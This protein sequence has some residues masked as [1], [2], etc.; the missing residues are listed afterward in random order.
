MKVIFT[1]LNLFLL[2]GAILLL[3]FTVLTGSS[4]HFPLNRF[5]W[6]EADTS[7]ISGAYST[8]RWTFWGVCDSGNYADCLL[9]PAYPISPVDNFG[10]TSG[11]PQKFVDDRDVYYYLTRFAFAFII[12]TLCFTALAFIIDILGFCFLII[13]KV[14]I[15]LVSLALFFM[16]GGAAL[17][18]AAIV[19]ARNAFRDDGL[20]AHIGTKSMALLWASFGCLLVVWVNTFSSNIMNS[21]HKHL[22][23]VNSEKYD[24]EPRSSTTVAPG[25]AGDESSFTR[26][27]PEPKDE[28]NNGGGIRYFKI[29]RNQK[30]SDEESV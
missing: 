20:Y 27:A 7:N 25:A 3:V 8:S 21:I 5:Y 19:L 29:K 16:A 2:A 26:T 22:A 23:N 9:G 13:D 24:N 14:V 1:I 11:I 30:T 6:L 10:N 28:E 15:C 18:T 4:K 17:Q 12:I